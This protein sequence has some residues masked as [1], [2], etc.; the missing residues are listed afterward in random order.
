MVSLSPF[1]K[2]RMPFRQAQGYHGEPVEPS[3]DKLRMAAYAPR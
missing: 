2:L 3:F 1:D